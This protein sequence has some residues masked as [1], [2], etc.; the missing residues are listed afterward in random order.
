MSVLEFIMVISLFSSALYTP[1][2]PI[3]RNVSTEFN[4][5]S[6]I[7]GCSALHLVDGK[8]LYYYYCSQWMFLIGFGLETFATA[9]GCRGIKPDEP[10]AST[11][12]VR[13]CATVIKYLVLS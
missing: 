5:L 4:Y 6:D 11:V 1:P 3:G 7:Q 12:C 9:L 13:V 2:I 10:Y 8:F